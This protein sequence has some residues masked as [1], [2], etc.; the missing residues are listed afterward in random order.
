MK[1]SGGR[2]GRA[3]LRRAAEP[4]AQPC[5]MRL[6]DGIDSNLPRRHFHFH[7]ETY[8]RLVCFLE[9]CATTTITPTASMNPALAEHLAVL[10]AMNPCLQRKVRQTL[11]PAP[12]GLPLAIPASS[13]LRF[14]GIR[15]RQ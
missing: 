15:R 7:H 2:I 10:N 14:Y 12:L 3:R 8:H 9:A 11:H 6:E 5:Q 4:A 13:L 1:S